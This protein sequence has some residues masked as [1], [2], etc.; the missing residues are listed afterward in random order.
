MYQKSK[1]NLEGD[2]TNAVIRLDNNAEFTGNN[3]VVTNTELLTE[4]YSNCSINVNTSVSIDA[5]GNSEIQLFG[6]QKVEIKRFIDNAT[7]KKKP[8]K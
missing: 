2:V 7:L 8:T 3:L 1:A 4:S 6:D 5:A